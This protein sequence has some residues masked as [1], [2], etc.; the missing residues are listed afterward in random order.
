MPAPAAHTNYIRHLNAFFA[1]VRKENRLQANHVSL[2]LALFQVWNYH[3]FQNPFPILR[4]EVMSLSC[5]GSRSTY[6]RCLKHLDHCRYIIY[7]QA[8]QAYAASYVSII[9]LA[10]FIADPHPEQLFLFQDPEA[11]SVRPK[12]EPPHPRNI[13]PHIRPNSGPH[14]GPKLGHFNKHINNSK[15][16]GE[17]SHTPPS[18][19]SKHE[20]ENLL[21]DLDTPGAARLTPS[22]SEAQEFFTACKYPETE[23][24]KFFHHYQANGWRQGGKTL[25]TNWQAAAHKWILNIHPLKPE[26]HDNHTSQSAGPGKL[27]TNEN[28]SYSEPL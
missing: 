20:T 19:K 6:V 17:N 27:H 15:R 4:E 22:L 18:K 23:A 5:I 7:A 9:S 8:R 10:D 14:A 11:A 1:Q 25:I 13:G 26:H 16:G 24:G 21:H 3:R 28:K 12:N 2:Y